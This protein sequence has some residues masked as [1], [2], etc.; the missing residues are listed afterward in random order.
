MGLPSFMRNTSGTIGTPSRIAKRRAFSCSL[1]SLRRILA[2]SA[3]TR[4]NSFDSLASGEELNWDLQPDYRRPVLSRAFKQ[5]SIGRQREQYYVERRRTWKACPAFSDAS[6]TL[7][8][9]HCLQK[10]GYL[11]VS[12]CFDILLF[13]NGERLLVRWLGL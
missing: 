12:S 6:W 9:P 3:G 7:S 10:L 4:P 11:E 2:L 5:L 1:S 13:W 8:S